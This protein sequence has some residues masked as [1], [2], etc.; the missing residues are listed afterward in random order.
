MLM[1][2]AELFNQMPA[3]TFPLTSVRLVLKILQE[4][5]IMDCIAEETC[6]H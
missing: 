5:D 4:I 1:S 2:R 6:R 3:A